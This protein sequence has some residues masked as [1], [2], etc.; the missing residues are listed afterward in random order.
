MDLSLLAQTHSVS[1]VKMVHDFTCF[2]LSRRL[3]TAEQLC[4]NYCNESLQQQ[5]NR[6]VFKL[7]QQEYERENIAWSFI[8]FPDNQD[9]LDLIE[10]KHSGIFSILDEQCRLAK[11]TDH[12][13][14]KVTYEKCEGPFTANRTQQAQGLFS[15]KHYAGE[16]EYTAETFL[17]KNKD[18]LPKE[19][20]D[21]LLSSTRN[22]FIELGNLLSCNNDSQKKNVRS[23]S[24]LSRASVASQFSSQLRE[25]RDNIDLTTPHYIRCLKPNDELVP[26]NFVP[27][28][29]ADQLRCAGVLE[30]VRVSRV[31]YPQRYSKEMFVQRYGVLSPR[32]YC[33][34]RRLGGRNVCDELV[35]DVVPQIWERQNTTVDDAASCSRNS[36]HQMATFDL[37]SVGIQLG[38]SKVFLRHHAF[39]TLE[40]LRSQKLHAS[41][42]RL[43]AVFRMSMER[44]RYYFALKSVLKLQSLF[45][46]AIASRRVRD[47]KIAKCAVLIQ[48]AWRGFGAYSAYSLKLFVTL[49]MQRIHRGNISRRQVQQ[50]VFERKAIVIQSFWRM[51][52]SRNHYLIQQYLAFNLQQCFRKKKARGV[53][54]I[55]RIEAKDLSHVA[56]E[57]DK[58]KKR[59]EEMKK[60][61]EE[62][63][64]L[65]MEAKKVSEGSDSDDN[66][67][68]HWRSMYEKKDLECKAK[69]AEIMRLKE[70]NETLYSE[71]HQ[72]R[73]STPTI[74]RSVVSESIVSSKRLLNNSMQSLKWGNSSLKT[75]RTD[76]D[77]SWSADT[78]QRFQS[79]YFD[80]PIHR[81]IRAADDDALSIA[82]SN[83]DDV[84]G[85]IN[86][87]GRDGRTPLHL[88]ILSKNLTSAEFLLQND[89][90][91]CNTQDDEG[92][93]PL[94]HAKDNAF[95]RLLL[96]AGGANPN[97]PNGAGFCA[98]HVAVQRRD[99]ESVKTLISYSANLNV[100]D[101]AKWLTPLHLVAQETLYD[102]KEN[103]VCYKE[104]RSPPVLEIA[105]AICGVTD[106]SKADLDFQ[107][108]G[109][110]TPLHH[111]A[112]LHSRVAGDLIS[113]FL[114]NNADPNVKNQRG[115]T[116]MHLLMHNKSL[117]RFDFFPDL[118][119]LML[120]QGC[121][122]NIQSMNGCTPLHLAIY[123]QDID[124]AIELMERESQLHLRWQKPARWEVHWQDYGS[125]NEV[126]ALDMI[127]NRET[128]HRILS[129]I[130]CEQQF[131]PPRPNCMQCKRK[132]AAFGKKNCFHCGSLV[133]ARCSPQKLEPS[134][135][136]PYCHALVG[137]EDSRVCNICEEILTSRKEEEETIMGRE[138]FVVAS[139]RQEE[140][141]ML[142]MECQN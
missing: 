53:L 63:N 94:H 40:F 80:T 139:S 16:V 117:R 11:C 38:K 126:Y 100:A 52:P 125:S 14:V 57:R 8:S 95:V 58:L 15:I 119:Q 35:D 130:T 115:Q 103:A 73:S 121:D 34:K 133:C 12:S 114:R 140:V 66:N 88:A 83:C 7:E 39:E 78:S 36:M 41:S 19:A 23:C 17:D 106:P 72:I 89:S 77:D 112:V 136:P 91:A 6:H 45:R 123:H 60:K 65:V 26:E 132:I 61:L 70:E 29:I 110:N 82:V 48:S 141:S 24:S 68:K 102:T 97:I 76:M 22:V 4:I 111:L 32:V 2:R 131:A 55:L 138:V 46:C 124:S 28:I 74:A 62:A 3:L 104:A 56:N 25:L 31:G 86:R 59:T 1:A 92:N 5:F 127:E 108:R 87:S 137:A 43:Q 96:G 109:G 98:I 71:L 10:K 75:S 69:D 64:R 42:I 27:I 99:V 90:V 118:I 51:F 20:T 142:D 67:W 18:E 129:S 85:D 79:D 54:K 101:D 84:T 120:F 116:P 50:L 13:F 33:R 44:K 9:V 93:T 21:F 113:L 105:K 122:T 30:A 107:D 135:F 128:M 47:I 134:F 49:Q 37:V 81:A